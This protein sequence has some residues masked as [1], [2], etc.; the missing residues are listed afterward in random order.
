MIKKEHAERGRVQ[1]RENEK[2]EENWR[3][4][5]KSEK[6]GE[7]EFVF[8]RNLFYGDQHLLLLL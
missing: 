7:S 3:R 4:E 1:R 8:N 6:R 2:G 5:E